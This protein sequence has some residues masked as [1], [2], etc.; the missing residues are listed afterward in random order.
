LANGRDTD[1]GEPGEADEPVPENTSSGSGS[2]MTRQEAAA[3]IAGL[4][5]GVKAIA[6]KAGLPFIAYLLGMA[7]EEAQVEESREK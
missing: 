6:Q 4:L 1:N 5:R 2:T 3:Y 7:I